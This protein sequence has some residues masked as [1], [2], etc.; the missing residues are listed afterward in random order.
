M[1]EENNPWCD[2]CREPHGIV[3]LNGTCEMITIYLTAVD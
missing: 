2:N 1:S 3:Q